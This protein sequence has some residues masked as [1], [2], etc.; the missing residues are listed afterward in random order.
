MNEIERI[1]NND[2]MGKYQKSENIL[3]DIQNIIEISQ[4]EAYRAV[5]T[6]LVQRNWLIGYRIAEEELG[7]EHR[8]EYG[9][10]IIKKLSKELTEKYGKGF[11]KSNLYNF[12]SFYKAY[13]E[14]F[15]FDHFITQLKKRAIGWCDASRVP[16]RPKSDG[17]AVMC[18]DED[19]KFWF[20]VLDQTAEALGITKK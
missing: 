13:P 18:E 17:I 1:D 5:N 11:T 4:K 7:G 10:D 12:Y 14:I 8:A 2:I 9:A 3:N 6:I 19:G 20:H 15:Q 16:V